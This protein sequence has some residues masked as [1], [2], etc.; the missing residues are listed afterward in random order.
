MKNGFIA[1]S[2]L[3]KIMISIASFILVLS[4]YFYFF[5]VVSA[6]TPEQ[7]CRLSVDARA[8]IKFETA[9]G[10]IDNVYPLNCKTVSKIFPTEEAED[11]FED[12]RAE[13]MYD[14]SEH[15]AKCWWMYGNGFYHDIFDDGGYND[16]LCSVC[17]SF[18]M[19]SSDLLDENPITVA[20]L[21]QFMGRNQYDPGLFRG[22]YG[23][24]GARGLYEFPEVSLELRRNEPYTKSGLYNSKRAL[25]LGL[26]DL[27]GLLSTVETN[28][29]GASVSKL[30]QDNLL[31]VVFVVVPSLKPSLVNADTDVALKLIH[32]WEIG[33]NDLNNG[34]VIIISLEDGALLYA[35]D[36]GSDAIFSKR[37]L[38]EMFDSAFLPL[39]EQGL[40]GQAIVKLADE[41]NVRLDALGSTLQLQQN[42]VLQ[43]SYLAYITGGLQG[44][45][46]D[47][48][49]ND[50]AKAQGGIYIQGALEEFKPNE[51]YSIIYIS[52]VWSGCLGLCGDD[53]TPNMIG[54]SVHDDLFSPGKNLCKVYE[55]DG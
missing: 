9:A 42:L 28:S 53:E 46:I 29:I 10:D 49:I 22:G 20:E 15:M 16:N 19:E 7:A 34:I 54:L 48:T 12:P 11:E 21:I 18:T 25:S 13:L 2:F 36:K 26:A 33:T 40:Y 47:A 38:E 45:Q 4:F 1:L 23:L 41:M 24:R 6:N 55:D 39:A 43:R 5:N 51:R 32:E 31:D 14:I 52:P 37:M 27:S 30:K 44:A 17:Y 35:T 8:N 3:A 50:D